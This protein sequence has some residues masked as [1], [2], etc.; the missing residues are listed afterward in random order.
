[1]S[2]P[3]DTIASGLKTVSLDAA[4]PESQFYLLTS[5]AERLAVDPE[6]LASHSTV[7]KDL[8]EIG[9]AEGGERE[10][11]V[12]ETAQEIQLLVHT[13]ETGGINDCS[14][15]S[16]KALARLGDKYNVRKVVSALYEHLLSLLLSSPVLVCAVAEE[17]GLNSLTTLAANNT[18]ALQLEECVGY[19]DL[20]FVARCRLERYHL[21]K[22][23][24][25]RSSLVNLSK[26]KPCNCF[27]SD[28][29]P[30]DAID[31]YEGVRDECLLACMGR[32]SPASLPHEMLR[33]EIDVRN[34]RWRAGKKD[35]EGCTKRF[36]KDVV[37][38]R[39]SWRG[40][41]V[42]FVGL[43]TSIYLACRRI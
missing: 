35:C 36:A 1:M 18:L 42:E 41:K 2:D 25:A 37:E 29:H 9:S 22:V 6:L 11:K 26:R 3:L 20:S 21:A 10:C 13:L 28:W 19:Q 31:S 30:R 4:E 33:R 15:T 40:K 7:F 17:A 23:E 16:L 8:L 27:R 5:D 12:S 38:V 14:A 24:A 34:G 43:P 39:D 32:L